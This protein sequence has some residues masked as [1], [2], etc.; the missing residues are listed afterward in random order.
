MHG[1]PIPGRTEETARWAEELGF[2]GLLL[3]D[4]QNLV[5]DPFVELG[6]AAR[7]TT[8]LR[9]GTGIVNLVTRHPAVIAAAIASVQIESGGRAMLGLGR[10]DSSLA[11]L[12]LGVPSTARFRQL[13]EQVRGYLCGADVLAGGATSR[14][15][16]IS[17]TGMAVVP[18]E[19]AAT[20]PRTI[21]LA[22]TLADRVMFT[23]GAAPARLACA[24]D[25]ARQARAAAGLDP[26]GL[27]A[28]AYL[29]IACHPDVAT[30]C[31]LVRG[32]AAIFAHFSSM[33]GSVP[34]GFGMHDAAVVDQVGTS[35]DATRHGSSHAPHA[36][37]LDDS[38]IA[39]FA[40][41]G[42]PARCITRLRQLAELGLD[43]IVFV[44]GSRDADPEVLTST[45][46]LFARDVL[47]VLRRP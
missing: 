16:W 26:Q 7:A 45:N 43:R 5:G 9:L 40:V 2:D 32:S 33:A 22:A 44:P 6:V 11:L 36:D 20:G 17:Q 24:I 27:R 39:R 30:A 29:N 47:P 23:V 1:F 14:I 28:G 46:E 41:V 15:G 12:N 31:G 34:G 25:R 21:A 13:V 35:Y 37:A 4:S 8:R 3:A 10:G 38:F 19:I 42:P 18:V